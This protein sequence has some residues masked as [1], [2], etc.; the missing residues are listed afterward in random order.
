MALAFKAWAAGVGLATGAAG[1]GSAAG[2][3]FE[4]ETFGAGVVGACVVWGR[5]TV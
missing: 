1:V 5:L 3:G 4:S 2:A